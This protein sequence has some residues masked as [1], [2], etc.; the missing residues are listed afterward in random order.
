MCSCPRPNSVPRRFCARFPNDAAMFAGRDTGIVLELA[1]RQ[2]D[3]N[4]LSP[5]NGA[6]QL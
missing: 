4:R 1:T 2:G 5:E 3:I 6:E